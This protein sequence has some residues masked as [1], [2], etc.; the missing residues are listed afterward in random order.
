MNTKIS[1]NLFEELEKPEIYEIKNYNRCPAYD[2]YYIG[3]TIE[4]IKQICEE[5]KE[6]YNQNNRCYQAGEKE[7]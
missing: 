7:V 1:E 6:R 4:A 2:A 5:C 3:V